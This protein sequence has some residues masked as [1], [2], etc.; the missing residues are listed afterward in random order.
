M[1]AASCLMRRIASPSLRASS[2]PRPR[3]QST[4]SRVSSASISTRRCHRVQSQGFR[5]KGPHPVRYRL[6]VRTA[7]IAAYFT[8]KLDAYE[9]LTA[10]EHEVI[11]HGNAWTLFPRFAVTKASNE[12]VKVGNAKVT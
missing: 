10:D 7:E 4:F 8:T 11:S 3:S 9:G 6:T 12:A 1:R 5:R 2:G